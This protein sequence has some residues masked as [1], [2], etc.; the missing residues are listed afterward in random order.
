VSKAD[1][2]RTPHV[3]LEVIP[4]A[5]PRPYWSALAGRRIRL[6]LQGEH[7]PARRGRSAAVL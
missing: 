4:P 5:T 3:I 7:S 1:G 6:E 2:E